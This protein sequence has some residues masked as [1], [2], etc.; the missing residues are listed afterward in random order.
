MSTTSKSIVVHPTPEITNSAL[1]R[2]YINDAYRACMILKVGRI[3]VTVQVVGAGHPIKVRKGETTFKLLQAEMTDKQRRRFQESIR[4]AR[5]S[6]G[7][8]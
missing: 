4:R 1:L 5:G 8:K 3:W 6:R 2:A 7:V